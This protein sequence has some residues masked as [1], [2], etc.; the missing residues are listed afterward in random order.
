MIQLAKQTSATAKKLSEIDSICFEKDFWS[1]KEWMTNY[2]ET[3]EIYFL[4]NENKSIMGYIVWN[5]NKVS[6]I[7]YLISIAILPEY[8]NQGYAKKLLEYNLED[9]TRLGV[10]YLFAHT[11]WSNYHSQ[12][13]L[14]SFGFKVN[15][16]LSN[17]YSDDE[18]AIEFIKNK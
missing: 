10:E 7:A 3:L 14:K 2:S 17:Y 8:R 9:F 5:I 13:L 1:K 11:R 12:K 6:N 18:D 4:R 15:S 16:I